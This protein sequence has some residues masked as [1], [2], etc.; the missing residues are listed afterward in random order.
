[1]PSNATIAETCLD[2]S[3]APILQTVAQ[4]PLRN[5]AQASEMAIRL[6]SLVVSTLHGHDT[7]TSVSSAAFT[8]TW[9]LNALTR[10]WHAVAL[11]GARLNES[12]LSSSCLTLFLDSSRKLLERMAGIKASSAIVGRIAL[13][14]SQVTTTFLTT[15][16]L[17]LAAPVERILCLILLDFSF[18]AQ[19]SQPIRHVFVEQVLSIFPIPAE[20]HGRF[21]RFGQDLQVCLEK[22]PRKDEYLTKC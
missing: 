18:I 10:F 9:T 3:Q 4:A 8:D 6:L 7:A 2:D 5:I 11:E 17:P 16:P 1:V 19:R 12:H 22:L 21:H 20:G 14:L 13:L 15:Q